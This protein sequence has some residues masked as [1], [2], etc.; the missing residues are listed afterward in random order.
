LLRALFIAGTMLFTSALT[1][2]IGAAQG[3]DPAP[4]DQELV[5]L[6]HGMGRTPLS[7]LP[8]KL[9]LEEVGF[10]VMNFGY[11]SY[12]PDINSIGAKLSRSLSE[13][14]SVRPA[15]RVHFV[16]HSLGNVIVRSSLLD[17]VW[18]TEV[19][20][21]VM[22]APPNQG[23]AAADRMAP[24]VGWL[25]APISELRTSDSTVRALPAPEGIEFAIVAGKDDGKV[26]I[27]ETCLAGAREHLLL[28]S[29]H[30]FI[31]L[32]PSTHQLISQ[33]LATGEVDDEVE[34]VPKEV[35]AP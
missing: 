9:H 13:E 11:S 34:R 29:A 16:G 22:L 2:T 19:G 12:G 35:C 14:L 33:F 6:V 32:R 24:Y 15:T 8:L 1:G 30:T 4:A 31:M 25:L 23:S 28:D 27:A 3:G 5:V 18:Q 10:R 20:R 17:R 7:M 21:V 26:S